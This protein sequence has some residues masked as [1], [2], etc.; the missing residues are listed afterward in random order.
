M[1]NNKGFTLVELMAVIVILAIIVSIAVPSSIAI[2]NKIKTKMYNTKVDMII[3]AAKLYGQDNSSVVSSENNPCQNP[4]TV[5]TLMDNGYIKKDDTDEKGNAIV[6]NPK[7]KS[8]MNNVKVC[9]YKKNNR[10]YAKLNN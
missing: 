7:D 4:V 2:S 1:K 3:D 8:S 9:I 5:K 10:V 6:Q